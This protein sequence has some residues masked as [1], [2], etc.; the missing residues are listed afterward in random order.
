MILVVR[1]FVI[2][3]FAGC[4]VGH[5]KTCHEVYIFS[6][7][8]AVVAAIPGRVLLRRH[9]ASPSGESYHNITLTLILLR[10]CCTTSGESYHD[11]P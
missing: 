2:L 6:V 10:Y 7:L 5:C 9:K 11:I 1:Y 8:S 4:R 3:F